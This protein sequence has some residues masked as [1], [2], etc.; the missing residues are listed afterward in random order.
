MNTHKRV[1][2]KNA[3]TVR[4]FIVGVVFGLIVTVGFWQ[5]GYEPANAEPIPESPQMYDYFGRRAMLHSDSVGLD[6]SATDTLLVAAI[7][8]SQEGHLV[9]ATVFTLALKIAC[10]G[11]GDSAAIDS[12]WWHF[13]DEDGNGPMINGIGSSTFITATPTDDDWQGA[14]LTDSK[15]W[16]TYPL[17]VY[18]GR[19]VLYVFGRSYTTMR[20]TTSVRAILWKG[21]P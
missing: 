14:T 17:R 15:F 19:G 10:F 9:G 16:Y 13:Y 2:S 12:A 3:K 5:C 20:D 6:T 1:E 7:D 11:A 21:R 4:M 8:T 18:R